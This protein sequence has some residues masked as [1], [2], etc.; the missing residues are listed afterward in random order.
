[1]LTYEEHDLKLWIVNT[2]S[3]YNL[4]Q[5]NLNDFGTFKT[6]VYSIYNYLNKRDLLHDEFDIKNINFNTLF[7]DLKE[8][9]L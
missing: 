3:F 9:F 4:V 8:Y 6:I 7:E 1:M 2:E 5:R